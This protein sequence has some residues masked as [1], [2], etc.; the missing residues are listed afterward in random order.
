M[1]V[2]LSA[3]RPGGLYIIEDVTVQIPAFDIC[4]ATMRATYAAQ[5]VVPGSRLADVRL[6]DI[7]G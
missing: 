7:L 6:Q 2:T 5:Q 1:V 3:L 4:E